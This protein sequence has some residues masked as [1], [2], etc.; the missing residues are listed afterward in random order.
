[1]SMRN[2]HLGFTNSRCDLGLH[3]EREIVERE[4]EWMMMMSE[5][6]K[7]YVTI[8]R[9]ARVLSLQPITWTSNCRN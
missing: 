6:K 5:V 1:M 8:F 2:L 3:R 7:G 4:S 9:R